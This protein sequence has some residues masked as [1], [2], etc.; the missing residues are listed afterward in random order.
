MTDHDDMELARDQHEQER[1]PM[2]E[3]IYRMGRERIVAVCRIETCW[4][5]IDGERDELYQERALQRCEH[6]V[7]FNRARDV[8]AAALARIAYFAAASGDEN[9]GL[10]ARAALREGLEAIA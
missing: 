8:F 4:F 2:R 1:G 6:L 7:D 5:V 3:G 9:T 10:T